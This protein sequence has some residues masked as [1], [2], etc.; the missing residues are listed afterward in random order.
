MFLIEFRLLILFL[1]AFFYI[2]LSQ[3][4]LFSSES[5]NIKTVECQSAK[6]FIT[7]YEYLRGQKQFSELGDNSTRIALEVAGACNGSAKRFIEVY[8]VL[9]KTDLTNRDSLKTSTELAQKTDQHVKAFLGIFKSAYAQ[10]GLDLALQDSINLA[11]KLALDFKGDVLNSENDFNEMV[12]FCLNPKQLNLS[13]KQCA[14]LASR[15][16]SYGESYD[17]K[18][19]PY[20]IQSFQYLTQ[21]D[22]VNLTTMDALK[23]SEELAQIHPSSFE[24]FRASYEYAISTKGL[25]RPKEEAMKIA[26]LISKKSIQPKLKDEK[27]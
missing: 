15:I 11:K 17:Q 6:E 23:I 2:E 24:N 7:V 21:K 25:A 14:E 12:D 3:A 10:D 9:S 19:T 16:S 8:Q 26:L 22:G 18:V 5:Q 4:S 13:K 20:F 1:A 27:Q